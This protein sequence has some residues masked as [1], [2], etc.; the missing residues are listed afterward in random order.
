M[1][2]DKDFMPVDRIEAAMERAY[3]CTNGT[4][5]VSGG[6]QLA[7]SLATEYGYD[8]VF[9]RYWVPFLAEVEATLW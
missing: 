6:L 1:K 8:A 5:D 7:E 2:G 3:I 9:E 4:G